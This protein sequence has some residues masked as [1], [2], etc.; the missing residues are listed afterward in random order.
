VN[1]D[2]PEDTDEH[3]I[4]DVKHIEGVADYQVITEDAEWAIDRMRAFHK[5]YL[6]MWKLASTVRPTASKSYKTDYDRIMSI[7][8]RLGGRATGRDLL[9]RT[10][11]KGDELQLLI[12]ALI[13]MHRIKLSPEKNARGLVVQY[14]KVVAEDDPY[15]EEEDG[16]KIPE[17]PT[18][19]NLVDR[20]LHGKDTPDA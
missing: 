14:Y 9:D 6:D 17:L 7:I 2:D 8:E 11:M 18:D 3:L 19:P 13:K 20:F 5:N 4:H 12:D 10:G 15:R 1:I 16:V